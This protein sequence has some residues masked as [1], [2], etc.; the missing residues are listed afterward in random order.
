MCQSSE[1]YSLFEHDGLASF[2]CIDHLY[3]CFRGMT[4]L[5]GHILPRV[6]RFHFYNSSSREERKTYRC[7]KILKGHP[8]TRQAT[9]RED[10][11]IHLNVG[12]P[13]G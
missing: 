5:G 1:D 6:R 8:N 10:S 12:S 13:Q 4:N 11:S 9:H 2:L 3:T 7:S